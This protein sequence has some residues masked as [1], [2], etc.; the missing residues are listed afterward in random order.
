MR[1]VTL[2]HETDFDGWR[3][4]ARQM[5]ADDIAPHDVSWSI[6]SNSCLFADEPVQHAMVCPP[7]F[8]ISRD[9]MRL[10]QA[11]CLHRDAD[12]YAFLYQLLWR[13]RHEPQLLSIAVDPDVVRAHSMQK[14]VQ[15][16]MHKMKAFVRFREIST[17]DEVCFVAWFEPTHHITMATAPF[18][19]RRFANMRWSIL[20]PETSVHWDGTQLHESA[21]ACKADVPAE[22][23]SEAL[24]LTYYASIF[25]PA[26]LK[27]ASMQGHM[28]KKYWR[29]LP[30]AGL[31]ASL[32]N[33]AA[34]RTRNMIDT[35][36]TEPRKHRKMAPIDRS[37]DTAGKPGRER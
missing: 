35:A 37:A 31:I 36:A 19:A 11:V 32:S 3:Q 15:R 17:V 16:D 26:R 9:F 30:E 20:T 2:A 25:N 34:A 13:Q 18:F 33:Q 1:R 22:D 14:A 8:T 24:W 28:P 29:N 4:S 6:G 27:L 7:H 23:A 10:C 21:G 5:L 12:R